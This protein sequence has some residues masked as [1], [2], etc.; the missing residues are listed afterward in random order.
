MRLFGIG[1]HV[2]RAA[3]E[4]DARRIAG[5]TKGDLRRGGPSGYHTED[6]ENPYSRAVH[7]SPQGQ[8]LLLFIAQQLIAT[9]ALQNSLRQ[10]KLVSLFPRGEPA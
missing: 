8:I 5:R 2:E 7:T 9:I 1:Q 10:V 3:A 4:R 6:E